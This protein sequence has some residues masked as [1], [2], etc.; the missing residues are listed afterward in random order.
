MTLDRNV[1]RRR[2]QVGNYRSHSCPKN[3]GHWSR[4]NPH[5]LVVEPRETNR[6]LALRLDE[7]RGAVSSQAGA[8]MRLETRTEFLS[9]GADVRLPGCGIS[10][11]C[12]LPRVASWLFR[13]ALPAS[14]IEAV[15]ACPDQCH[16]AV[17]SPD[18]SAIPAAHQHLCL[19]SL[20]ASGLPASSLPFSGL[21]SLHVKPPPSWNFSAWAAQPELCTPCWNLSFICTTQVFSYVH[22]MP[23]SLVCFLKVPKVSH[24]SGH[25]SWHLT[26][27]CNFSQ[28]LSIVEQINN[29]GR[30]WL[31]GG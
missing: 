10:G 1:G 11:G 12:L 30:C 9:H 29:L 22:F 21:L 2:D 24:P 7:D 26:E 27:P 5:I 23:W 8:L 13:R 31:A 4:K 25:L 16:S 28:Y 6:L 14:G 17:L 18:A 19:R 3:Q 15:D 20:S